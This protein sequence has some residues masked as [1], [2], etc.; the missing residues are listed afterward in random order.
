MELVVPAPVICSLG[1]SDQR[2]ASL[3]GLT[4]RSGSR[5]G[6]RSRV[7]FAAKMARFAGYSVIVTYIEFYAPSEAGFTSCENAQNVIRMTE[8]L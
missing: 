2:E 8:M 3:H 7:I 1:W 5:D 6:V 4:L